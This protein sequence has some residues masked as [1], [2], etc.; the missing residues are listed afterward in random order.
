MGRV[1]HFEIQAS[2]PEAAI[3]FYR[4]LFGWTFQRWDQNDYWLIT[5]GLPAQPG[6][7]GG[8]LPRRGPKAV[9]GQPV[10]CFVCTVQVDA[11]DAA[12]EKAISLGAS[13][14]VPKTP[15]PGIGSLAYIK[16]PD[17]NEIELYIDVQP[18]LW[19]EQPLA[20]LMGTRP[21]RI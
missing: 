5:T 14:A 1:V 3:H 4:T 8:L 18:E 19:R 17:G 15:I 16:D 13:V 11:L 21:L 9:D 6:I 10:N 7:D 20:K 12:L 2:Q